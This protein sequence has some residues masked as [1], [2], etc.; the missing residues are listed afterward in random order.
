M[1]MYYEM[2]KLLQTG[3]CKPKEISGNN[4]L[5]GVVVYISMSLMSIE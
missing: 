3:S 4:R 1:L 5:N 2:T